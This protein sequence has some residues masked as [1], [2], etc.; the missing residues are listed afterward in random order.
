MRQ[1]DLLRASAEGKFSYKKQKAKNCTKGKNA[2]RF[3]FWRER[4]TDARRWKVDCYL[5]E[6]RKE[7]KCSIYHFIKIFRFPT[8]ISILISQICLF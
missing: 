2:T 1:T 4:G 3:P 6:H 7:Q 5:L 8:H